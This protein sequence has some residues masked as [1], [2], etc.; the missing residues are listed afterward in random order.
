M[1]VFFVALINSEGKPSKTR[2]SQ[3]T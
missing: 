2:N 3:N 1:L